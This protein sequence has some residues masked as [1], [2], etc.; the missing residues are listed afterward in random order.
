MAC[1]SLPYDCNL[2]VAVDFT[3]FAH[4][5]ATPEAGAQSRS[6]WRPGGGGPSGRR[7]AVVFATGTATCQCTGH[8]Q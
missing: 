6:Q 1:T 3:R 5:A 7:V 8:N 2:S 4:I